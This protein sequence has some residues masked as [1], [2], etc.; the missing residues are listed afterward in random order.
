MSIELTLLVAGALLALVYVGAQGL[1]LKADVGNAATV[2]ARDTMPAAGPLS[3]R[4]E[5]ALRNFL[6]TF[7]VFVALVVV[8]ELAGRSDMLTQWGAGLYV[9]MRVL[10]LPLYLAGVRWLRT[11]SW[12]L[13]TT[14]LA[15]MIIGIVW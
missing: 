13:A 8:V 15:L 14:G 7:P 5:R 9:G 1:I 2:G 3:G 11:F 6:E 4:A 10:Y 12:N